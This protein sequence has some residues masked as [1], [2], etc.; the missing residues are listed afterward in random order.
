[1][2]QF[3]TTFIPITSF[4]KAPLHIKLPFPSQPTIW[5]SLST[6][7]HQHF[8]LLFCVTFELHLIFLTKLGEDNKVDFPMQAMKACRGSRYIPV[9]YSLV[10][11]TQDE[12]HWSSSRPDRFIPRDRT[13]ATNW[14]CSYVG[15]EPVWKFW[16]RE[17]SLSLA[18][19]WTPYLPT[20]SLGT[21]PNIICI[22]VTNSSICVILICAHILTSSFSYHILPRIVSCFS[23][24]R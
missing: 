5:P 13:L 2:N 19:N 14:I 22:F 3:Q 12:V 6:F 23:E 9:G 17:K 20:H 1:M 21:I 16:K 8:F 24:L 15:S 11:L 18:G 7:C 4:C 10:T